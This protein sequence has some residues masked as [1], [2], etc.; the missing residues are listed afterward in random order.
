MYYNTENGGVGADG[1]IRSADNKRY[2]PY[3]RPK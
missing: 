1:R 2:E 3:K